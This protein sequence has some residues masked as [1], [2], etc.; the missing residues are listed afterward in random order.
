MNI[1]FFAAKLIMLASAVAFC[2]CS[3]ISV[4][5]A[6]TSVKNTGDILNIGMISPLSGDL[7]QYGESCR[8][9]AELAVDEINQAGGADGIMFDISFADDEGSSE[10]AAKAY[11]ELSDKNIN[12]LISS[13]VYE[14]AI[15]SAEKSKDDGILNIIPNGNINDCGSYENSRSLYYNYTS[16]GHKLYERISADGYKSIAVLYADDDMVSQLLAEAF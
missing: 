14:S 6:E 4:K 12:T 16:M 9:A 7:K 13:F 1:R 8:Y 3:P 10:G 15:I 2:G 5:D 11:K